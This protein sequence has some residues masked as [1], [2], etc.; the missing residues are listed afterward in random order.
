MLF[1]KS[2]GGF[3]DPAIHGSNIPSDAIEITNAHYAAMMDAQAH[4]KSIQADSNGKPF[5]VDP[6]AP[7]IEQIISVFT[8]RIQVR[9]DDFAMTRGYD[10]ILSACSY[11][12]SLVPK[13]KAEGQ[14]CVEARDA[15][16]LAASTILNDVQTGMRP[17]PTPEE[18]LAEMP[19]LAW[20]A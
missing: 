10:S 6:P 4:G 16:W 2:T 8:S 1:A 15:T 11:A 17:V 5:A 12:T 19:A 7:T 3:Y 9:L 20:P 13:F 18:V 14:Y